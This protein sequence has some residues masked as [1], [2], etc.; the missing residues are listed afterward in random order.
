MIL[1]GYK[2]IGISCGD[3]I[4]KFN[5]DKMAYVGRLDPMA[6]GLIT[7]LTDE[8]VK[9]MVVFMKR[10]KTYI[11]KFIIGINTD[12]DDVLGIHNNDQKDITI[13]INNI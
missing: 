7:I 10:S 13:N 1:T 12:T 2:P 11:F 6:H 4:K 5:F 8:D 9:Q 3:F